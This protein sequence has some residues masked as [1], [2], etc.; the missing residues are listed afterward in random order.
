MKH[1]LLA[2][3]FA[4]LASLPS[5]AQFTRTYSGALT[6]TDPTIPGDRLY[7]D[8]S[9]AVCGSAK[10]FPGTST[11]AGVHYDTYT[12]GN[13][14]TTASVCVTIVV[15]H[16]C[17]EATTPLIFQ[18]V[19]QTSFVPASLTTNYKSDAGSSPATGTNSSMSVTLAPSEVI[20]L[21]ISGLTSTSL[22]S[23]YTMT[24]TAPTALP[25]RTGQEAATALLAYPNPVADVLHIEAAKAGS[26]T[27]YNTTGQTVKTITGSEVSLRDLPSG[28]YMLQQADTRELPAWLS[29]RA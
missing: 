20:A 8:A 18:S 27:L 13:P 14:S 1:F 23:A 28:V 11:G 5:H 24:V 15:Q 17:T 22:C 29:Y 2:A 9:T 26:Y 7:R 19:Y 12:V 4:L 6:A 25:V 21:V 10:V 3:G 16:S